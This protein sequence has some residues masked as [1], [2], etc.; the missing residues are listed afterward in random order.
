MK[1]LLQ[2]VAALFLDGYEGQDL[3]KFCYF[4]I[5]KAPSLAINILLTTKN[6]ALNFVKVECTILLNAGSLTKIS[7]TGRW[8][9]RKFC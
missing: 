4:N 5:S 6:S 2:L 7:Y 9:A 3:Q 8:D 1:L